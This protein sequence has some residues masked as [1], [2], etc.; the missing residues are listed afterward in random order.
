MNF[1]GWDNTGGTLGG[2]FVSCVSLNDNCFVRK[3][4]DC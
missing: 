4:P 3:T 2:S 1:A